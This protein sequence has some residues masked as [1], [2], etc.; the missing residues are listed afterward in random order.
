MFQPETFQTAALILCAYGKAREGERVLL[1]TDP[2]YSGDVLASLQGQ[3]MARGLALTTLTLLPN[4]L[5]QP[6]ET[7]AKI[8]E[9]VDLVVVC[10]SR[11][12]HGSFKDFQARR[13]RVLSLTRTTPR[14]LT[15]ALSLDQ[16]ALR[17]EMAW[18]G[19]KLANCK[20][21]ELC[22][23]LGTRLSIKAPER[24]ILSWDG[25]VEPGEFD[26]YPGVV[27]LIPVEAEIEGRF[28][29]D[30]TV[31]WL[32]PGE[33]ELFNMTVTEPL[34]LEVTGGRVVR[35]IGGLE[36]PRIQRLLLNGGDG[37]DVVAEIGLGLNSSLRAPTGNL[38]L[39][40]HVYG[41]AHVGVGN[42]LHLGGRN[43]SGQHVDFVLMDA[44]II[45]DG[46]PVVEEGMLRGF[47]A[48]G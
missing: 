24:K 37:A 38:L 43:K 41:A 45:C 46:K 3:A 39:D 12:F 17:A 34:T 6:P 33:D 23:A 15:C 29:V 32:P 25:E 1:V 22:T 18:F 20:S 36:A 2:G 9:V 30:C 16:K 26:T 40:E 8:L 31:G 42:N 4:Q 13:G 7:F 19:E 27:S 48:R 35:V 28:V 10:T 14:Q 44:T 47:E 5:R 11:K 21:L